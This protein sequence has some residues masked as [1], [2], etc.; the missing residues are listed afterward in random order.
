VFKRGLYLLNSIFEV[1]ASFRNQQCQYVNFMN[2][3]QIKIGLVEREFG[4]AAH[5]VGGGYIDVIVQAPK[6]LSKNW[7]LKIVSDPSIF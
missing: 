4:G 6:G 7:M 2:W 5:L 1:I 3:T